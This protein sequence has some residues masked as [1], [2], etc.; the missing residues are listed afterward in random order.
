MPGAEGF[1]NISL[2]WTFPD[3]DLMHAAKPGN[4]LALQEATEPLE[5]CY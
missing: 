4:G 2:I 3:A 1:Q 5:K